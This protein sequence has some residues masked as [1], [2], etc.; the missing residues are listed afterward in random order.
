M[1]RHE[2]ERHALSCSCATIWAWPEPRPRYIHSTD[3]LSINKLCGEGRGKFTRAS[4]FPVE[5][6]PFFRCES[7][8][9][10]SGGSSYRALR[11]NW[12]RRPLFDPAL[13]RW[14]LV[15]I[16]ASHTMRVLHIIDPSSSP[17][18]HPSS[19]QQRCTDEDDVSSY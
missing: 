19:R 17:P 13:A 9:H 2:L 10:L 18:K 7:V 12:R 11:K 14:S 16:S 3:D 6:H 4:W 5:A 8:D 1:G 15:V